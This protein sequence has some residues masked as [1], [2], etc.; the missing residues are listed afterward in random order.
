M[1]STN[2]LRFINSKDTKNRPERIAPGNNHCK[3][4]LDDMREAPEGY[5]HCH[6]VNEAKR[7]IA[8]REEKHD[9]I[10]VIDCDHDLGDYAAD[11][12][13]GIKPIDRPA[14]RKTFYH[15]ALHTV[16]PVGRENMRRTIERYWN[17]ENRKD[18]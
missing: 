18:V 15:V 17:N 10:D 11:G 3:I 13:A 12:G 14:E 8:E 2:I 4:W 7:K 16:N 5:I 6:S 9:V 1:S